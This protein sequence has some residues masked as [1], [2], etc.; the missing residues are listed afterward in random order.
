MFLFQ[1]PLVHDISNIFHDVSSCYSF[2]FGLSST[3]VR[4]VFLVTQWLSLIWDIPQVDMPVLL[5]TWKLLGR[6]SRLYPCFISTL[7]GMTTTG[8]ATTNQ[9]NF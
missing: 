1:F 9:T 2:V 5:A 4:A 3:H 7:V 8:V 6:F